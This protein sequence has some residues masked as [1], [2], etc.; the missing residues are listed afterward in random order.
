MT[1]PRERS[2]IVA[3]WLE[4]GPYELP[5]STRRAIAVDVRTTHQSRRSF[6]FPWR[7]RKVDRPSLVALAA[8]AVIVVA[9][10]GLTVSRIAPDGGN[11]GGP[12]PSPWASSSPSP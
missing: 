8:V 12:S 9:V 6:W 4:D 10:A 11:V 1:P 2:A 3:A 7:F 5:E